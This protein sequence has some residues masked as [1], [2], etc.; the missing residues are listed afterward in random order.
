MGE[1]ISPFNGEDVAISPILLGASEDLE[2]FIQN[3]GLVD[4]DISGSVSE[5][6]TS[7]YF[8]LVNQPAQ[9]ILGPGESTSFLIQFSPTGTGLSV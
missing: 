9:T 4:L 5:T 2:V 7:D 1:P 6:V 8:N 3:R